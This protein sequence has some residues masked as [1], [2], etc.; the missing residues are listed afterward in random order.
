MQL[1]TSCLQCASPFVWREGCWFLNQIWQKSTYPYHPRISS[2][3]LS[4][5]ILLFAE[6]DDVLS[7]LVHVQQ[8]S[9][10]VVPRIVDTSHASGVETDVSQPRKTVLSEWN[11]KMR[12]VCVCVCVCVWGGGGVGAAELGRFSLTGPTEFTTKSSHFN[13]SLVLCVART[14]LCSHT[15]PMKTWGIFEADREL[16]TCVSALGIVHRFIWVDECGRD[17]VAWWNLGGRC[18]LFRSVYR[19][20]CI[21]FLLLCFIQPFW[22]GCTI[23]C[24][25]FGWIKPVACAGLNSRSVGRKFGWCYEQ[26]RGPHFVVFVLRYIAVSAPAQP[27]RPLCCGGS[28]IMLVPMSQ[29]PP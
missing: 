25:V 14:C 11:Y 21:G 1:V 29:L 13:C 26:G 22:K 28:R 15:V 12:K 23:T 16:R 20:L 7:R 24:R 27:L 17:M 10:H 2:F 6:L 18:R 19:F 9:S 3:S 5:Y 4:L 8:G